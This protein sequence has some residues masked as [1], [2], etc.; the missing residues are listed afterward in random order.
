M[1]PQNRPWPNARERFRIGSSSAPVGCS[2][3]RAVNQAPVRRTGPSLRPGVMRGRRRPNSGQQN[4]LKIRLTRLTESTHRL[5]GAGYA[6][7][8]A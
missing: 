3:L 8:M 7:A 6:E 5:T 4:S 2:D 1:G